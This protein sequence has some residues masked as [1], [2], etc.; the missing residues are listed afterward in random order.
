MAEENWTIGKIQTWGTNYLNSKSI[1]DSKKCIDLLLC[2]VL[3]LERIDLYIK[4]ELPLNVFELNEIKE[5]IKRLVKNEPLQYVLGDVSFYGL[6]FYVNSNVLIPRPETEE[7]V[8]LI[9]KENSNKSFI[10]I[11][12]IGCGSGCIGISL[13]KSFP[14]AKCYATDISPGAIETAKLNANANEINNIEFYVLDILKKIP[15]TKFDI[16]VS[17]P[18]YIST[19]EFNELDKNVK[20]FEPRAALTDEADGLS[21][22][23]RFN[24]IFESMLTEN[25]IFYFENSYEQGEKISKIFSEKYEVETIKDIN[26]IERFV[27]GVLRN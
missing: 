3:N 14:H 17:N 11:L 8:D 21:F 16:I 22:Y 2:N 12:D 5:K 18:P 6:K 19:N 4:N 23:R 26:R 9:V 13:A 1:E 25:G 7:L 15:K 27:K 10:N 24:E 20:D